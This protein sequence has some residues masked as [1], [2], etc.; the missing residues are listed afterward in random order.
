MRDP[1]K[2]CIQ[3]IPSQVAVGNLNSPP[4]YILTWLSTILRGFFT[5]GHAPNNIRI[6]VRTTF[7]YLDTR[8]TCQVTY[9]PRFRYQCRMQDHTFRCELQFDEEREMHKRAKHIKNIDNYVILPMQNDSLS[10]KCILLVTCYSFSL[11]K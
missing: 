8:D 5:G 11:K 1:F 7:C 6:D 10:P 9:V 4:Q 3:N 2:F